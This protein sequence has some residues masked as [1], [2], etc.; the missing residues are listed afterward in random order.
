ML[1][2]VLAML[3]SA[4]VES[5]R[6]GIFHGLQQ[7]AEAQASGSTLPRPVTSYGP[8]VVPLS[9]LWQAPSYILVG[10]SEVLASIAQLEF[11][12]DQAPDVMRSCSMALQLLS[13]AVGSYLG[14]GLVAAVA[15]ATS[16]AG[17]P[18]L[19]KDLNHGHLDYFLLLCAGLMLVNTLLFVAVANKYEYKVG[20]CRCH[21][22]PRGQ[23]DMLY[24][25]AMRTNTSHPSAS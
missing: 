23:Q 19:P 15:A 2:A 10:A 4:G 9:I 22:P 24:T 16:A 21:P 11:F 8:A 25:V 1:L 17:N 6:L 3:Y 12:Y 5:W 13:T 20:P 14:G 18:W 7:A